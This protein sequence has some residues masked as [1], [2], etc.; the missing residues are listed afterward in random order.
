MNVLS[1]WNSGRRN[2]PPSPVLVSGD[3]GCQGSSPHQPRSQR[4]SAGAGGV[5]HCPGRWTQS[6]VCAGCGSPGPEPPQAQQIH[7][8]RSCQAKQ[9][10]LASSGNHHWSLVSI[11]TISNP[12]YL[13]SKL[14]SYS[15]T[16]L[17]W[18]HPS[19]DQGTTSGLLTIM[20]P[21]TVINTSWWWSSLLI[22][23]F[24]T[25]WIICHWH[26]Y[27]RQSYTGCFC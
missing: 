21:D 25:P 5:R 9:S 20:L 3:A 19:L 11:L 12:P 18:T 24:L 15:T 8:F 4:C 26:M 6:H 10:N 1:G 27:S 22:P 14:N 7:C 23:N 2:H 16:I 13:G 17:S